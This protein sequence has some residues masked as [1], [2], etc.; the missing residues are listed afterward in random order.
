[1]GRGA[2]MGLAQARAVVLRQSPRAKTGFIV[3]HT[4][5]YVDANQLSSSHDCTGKRMS[6]G[7]GRVVT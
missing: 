5:W 4:V 2:R 1:M 3:E 6:M 7:E